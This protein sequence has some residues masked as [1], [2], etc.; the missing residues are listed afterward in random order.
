MVSSVEYCVTTECGDVVDITSISTSEK[1]GHTDES[2][3]LDDL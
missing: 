1:L 3:N 2:K